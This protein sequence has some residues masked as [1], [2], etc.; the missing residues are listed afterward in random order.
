MEQIKIAFT[1][2]CL[3]TLHQSLETLAV[4][5]N[6]ELANEVPSQIALNRIVEDMKEVESDYLTVKTRLVFAECAKAD[7]PM[8]AAIL[9]HSFE[10]LRHKIAKEGDEI[11]IVR[12]VINPITRP[13][14]LLAFDTYLKGTASHDNTWP[15]MV[16]KLTMLLTANVA[17]NLGIDPKTVND[18]FAM[19]EI[20]RKLEMGGTPTSNTQLLKQVQ[21]I[22]DALIYQENPETHANLY[23]AS[24][25][26][27]A[28]LKEI[29]SKKGK[30][31]LQVACAKPSFMRQIIADIA[32]RIIG[33]KLYS[34]EFAKKKDSEKNPET[35]QPAKNGKGN[36]KKNGKGKT[37]PAET[38][39]E[40]TPA[41]KE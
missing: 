7:R 1:E 39:E 36:G 23:Q 14:D 3:E 38:A 16:T 20:A 25:H 40:G 37:A 8:Y 19:G 18:S 35:V 41:V 31:E 13:I 24:S 9:K 5:Y 29:F 10:T 11:K 22:L 4:A 27:V 12:C 33:N 17:K 21:K 2:E 30:V 34:V 28:Y 15:H 6:T 32:Y 26:D